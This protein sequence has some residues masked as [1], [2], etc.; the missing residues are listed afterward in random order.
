MKRISVRVTMAVASLLRS[1]ATDQ[2]FR[3]E[4]LDSRLPGYSSVAADF[5]QNDLS[6][7]S[8]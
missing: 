5:E 4:F 8:G 3:R 7:N 6:R 1:L 2:L